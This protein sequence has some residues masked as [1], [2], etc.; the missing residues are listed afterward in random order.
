MTNDLL[1]L[2]LSDRQVVNDLA[3]GGGDVRVRRFGLGI[4]LV[5]DGREINAVD[6]KNVGVCHRENT[7][8]KSDSDSDDRAGDFSTV[9]RSCV[10]VYVSHMTRV[11]RA[12]SLFRRNKRH[13]S[14]LVFA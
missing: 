10:C 3:R 7:R 9:E 2:G 6:K 12:R 1:Y 5:V 4:K 8:V 11:E 13:E 14:I